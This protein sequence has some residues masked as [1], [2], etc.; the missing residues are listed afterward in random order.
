[1]EAPRDIRPFATDPC[2]GPLTSPD[3]SGLGFS[4]EGDLRTL[5]V[6]EQ[7]CVRQGTGNRSRVA[8]IVVPARDVLVDTYRARQFAI[9]RPTVIGGLPATFEQSSSDS[10]TCSTTVGT[11][12]QQGFIVNFS[13]Y[14]G[15]GDAGTPCIGGQRIAERIV[16]A[17]PPLPGK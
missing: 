17:L 13:A 14:A 4:S 6:G 9:F 8:L 1:M 11:A 12:D 3:W 5:M 7:S 15:A 10:L 2:S 16:A